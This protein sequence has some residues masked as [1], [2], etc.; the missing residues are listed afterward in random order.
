MVEILIESNYGILQIGI[1]TP[2]K[3]K[4]VLTFT[5][6]KTERIFHS[7]KHCLRKLHHQKS[8]TFSTP[9]KAHWCVPNEMIS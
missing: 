4:C 6:N 2:G 5:N 3:N 9:G 7:E 8:K 1:I